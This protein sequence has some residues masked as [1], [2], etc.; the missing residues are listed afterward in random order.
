MNR[1][2]GFSGVCRRQRRT[3]ISPARKTEDDGSAGIPERI[4]FYLVK[5]SEP[6]LPCVGRPVYKPAKGRDGCDRRVLQSWHGELPLA[7]FKI[8]AAQVE[9][10]EWLSRILAR[11]NQTSD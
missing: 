10:V 8:G 1:P 6:I 9:L 7:Q 3:S 2:P 5:R 11:T 4:D